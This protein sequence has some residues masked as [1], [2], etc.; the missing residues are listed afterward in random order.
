ML[1]FW[2]KIRRGQFDKIN[3][4]IMLDWVRKFLRSNPRSFLIENP[5]FVVLAN[6]Y[7]SDVST[8]RPDDLIEMLCAVRRADLAN[9][10]FQERFEDVFVKARK[11]NEVLKSIGLKDFFG[12]LYSP[13]ELLRY[14]LQD[15]ECKYYEYFINFLHW[16]ILEKEELKS[17][18]FNA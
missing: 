14:V 15:S 9:P 13:G 5:M 1:N 10:L 17:D 18:A 12:V 2:P 8:T 16:K 11:E 4:L 6:E 3:N 7:I